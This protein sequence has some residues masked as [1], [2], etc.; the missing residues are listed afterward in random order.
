LV[1]AIIRLYHVSEPGVLIEREFTSAVFARSFYF[2]HTD[3][4]ADWQREIAA[5]TKQNQP[6]LEPPITEYLVSLIYR[7]IGS[8]Q[9]WVSHILTALFWLIGGI[10]FYE[11]AKMVVSLK[12]AVI[13]TIYY[14]FT[15]LSILISR[16]FQPDA[17]MMMLFLISLYAILK[18]YDQ[19]IMSRLLLAGGV[20][21]LALLERPLV[22]FALLGV[23]I[24]LAI[25]HSKS[26]KIFL[27]EILSSLWSL[28]CCLLFCIMAMA[29]SLLNFCA[30]K[31][32]PVSGLI[33]TYIKN[34]GPAGCI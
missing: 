2:D 27:Q 5:I 9:L 22:L 16:S 30:G 23:Y 8:E 26:W 15:P 29:Y 1:A 10:F 25:Y 3:S 20:T 32:S 12:A 19:P 17:L 33:S 7:A 6:I 24:S 21:G 14:L 4:V 28:A 13:A 18:Y 11:M 31:W 34:I